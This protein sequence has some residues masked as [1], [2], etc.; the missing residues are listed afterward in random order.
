MK[1]YDLEKFKFAPLEELSNGFKKKELVNAFSKLRQEQKDFFLRLYPG[2]IDA[3]PPSKYDWAYQQIMRT[4]IKNRKE[5]RDVALRQRALRTRLV[6]AQKKL[7][8]IH[9]RR[10]L[11]KGSERVRMHLFNRYVSQ[12]DLVESLQA[13]IANLESSEKS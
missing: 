11:T 3:M 9:D 13:E 5:S 6:N 2:G 10:L 8:A 1:I 7:A 4:I 12:R